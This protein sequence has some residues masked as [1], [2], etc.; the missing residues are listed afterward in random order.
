MRP[1]ADQQLG[2]SGQ[3]QGD[4]SGCALS[5]A[6]NLCMLHSLYQYMGML[7]TEKGG[8]VRA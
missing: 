8:Q 2:V 1:P 3:V 6:H 5:K 4:A 7:A